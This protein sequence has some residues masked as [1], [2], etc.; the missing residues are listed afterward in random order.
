MHCFPRSS[1]FIIHAIIWVRRLF[2]LFHVTNLTAFGRF[3]KSD[4]TDEF[5]LS[6]I[7]IQKLKLTDVDLEG[8]VKTRSSSL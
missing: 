2:F 4:A 1:E 3:T 5:L 7:A 8:A 6:A